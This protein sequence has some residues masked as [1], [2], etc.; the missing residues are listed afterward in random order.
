MLRDLIFLSNER[1]KR[2]TPMGVENST[3]THR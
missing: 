1:D 3:E 2:W